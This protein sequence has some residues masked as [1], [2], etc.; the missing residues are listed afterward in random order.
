MDPSFPK[1]WIPSFPVLDSILPKHA[2]GWSRAL[3][4]VAKF[5]VMDA[6][7]ITYFCGNFIVCFPW[8]S[9][10]NSCSSIPPPAFHPLTEASPPE[11]LQIILKT[12]N[13]GLKIIIQRALGW[14]LRIVGF[15][16]NGSTDGTQDGTLFL[17]QPIR[18]IH[19]IPASPRYPALYLGALQIS[20]SSLCGKSGQCRILG[21]IL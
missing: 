21:T 11:L 3:R 18:V 9:S 17:A 6:N 13:N 2:P 14:I 5:P 16:P 20:G 1:L 12:W 15:H 19:G 4:S 10:N 8:F 7:V